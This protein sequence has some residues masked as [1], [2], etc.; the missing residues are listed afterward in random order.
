MTTPLQLLRSMCDHFGVD[1]DEVRSGCKHARPLR[2]R[3]LAVYVLRMDRG[4]TFGEISKLVRI[5]RGAV[6]RLYETAAD[7]PDPAV[8]RF[9]GG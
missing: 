1:E 3:R 5:S 8:G 6:H 2:V 4:C 7:R 9:I